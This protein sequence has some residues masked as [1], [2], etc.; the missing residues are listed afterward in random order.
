MSRKEKFTPYEKEQAC[1]DYINGNGFH[2]SVGLPPRE[3]LNS[4]LIECA[5][6][7]CYFTKVE[8][9]FFQKVSDSKRDFDKHLNNI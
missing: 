7:F 2:F 1:L 9:D 3:D 8:F 4:V 5:E 6:F